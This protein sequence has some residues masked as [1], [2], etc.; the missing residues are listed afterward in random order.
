[1]QDRLA[2]FRAKLARARKHLDELQDAAEEY[3]GADP[4]I[5]TGIFDAE[6]KTYL[7]YAQRTISI[8]LAWSTIAGDVSHNLFAALDYLAWELVAA[9]GQQG[10]GSTAFPLFTERAKFNKDAPR[11]MK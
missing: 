6:S 3:F 9:N 8:P 2:G 4:D 1:M 11:K 5:L 10:T 7:F